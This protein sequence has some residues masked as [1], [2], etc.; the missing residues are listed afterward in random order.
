MHLL[1]ELEIKSGRES[2]LALD[3]RVMI[4]TLQIFILTQYYLKILIYRQI[5]FSITIFLKTVS[6]SFIIIRFSFLKIF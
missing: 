5:Y 4:L 1:T 2:N 3:M 6:L